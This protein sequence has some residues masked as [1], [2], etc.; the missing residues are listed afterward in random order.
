MASNDEATS[1]HAVGNIIY[2]PIKTRNIW[3]VHVYIRGMGDTSP[4][5]A[6][7]T[8]PLVYTALTE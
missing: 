5:L 7:M 3:N 1:L 6:A 4:S 8:H 2:F